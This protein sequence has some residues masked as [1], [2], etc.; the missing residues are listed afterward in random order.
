MAEVPGPIERR[1]ANQERADLLLAREHLQE[2][3]ERLM[4]KTGGGSFMTVE[5]NK[6]AF[7][8]YQD[9]KKI[10]EIFNKPE[11]IMIVD[12]MTGLSRIISDRRRDNRESDNSALQSWETELSTIRADIKEQK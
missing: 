6:T 8:I 5:E 4:Q 1:A 3:M 9:L 7:E 11:L 10:E 12:K 2:M